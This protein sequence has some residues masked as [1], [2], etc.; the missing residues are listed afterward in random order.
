MGEQHR[1]PM[2]IL[3]AIATAATLRYRHFLSTVGAV[4]VLRTRHAR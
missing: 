3:L 1:G 2:G 4:N